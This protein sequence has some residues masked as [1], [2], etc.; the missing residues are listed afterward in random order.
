MEKLTDLAK[1][2]L[3][4]GK[5]LGVVTTLMND[6]SPQSSMVWVDTDG[7]HVIFNTAEGRLKPKNLRR[8]PRTSVVIWNAENPY[9]QVMIRGEVVEFTYEGADDHINS[10]AKKYL[11]VDEYPYR[12]E[13]EVR[14]IVK[15]RPDK[16]G[17]WG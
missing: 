11:G 8:D 1:T 5:N 17:S 9:Q 3:S 13:G 4:E 7:D 2:L 6:G 12:E 16:V 10:L 14:I 15:I